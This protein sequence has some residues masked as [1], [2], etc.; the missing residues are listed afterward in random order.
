MK[1]RETYLVIYSSFQLIA[2]EENI[3]EIYIKYPEAVLAII[4]LDKD[5]IE[6][7]KKLK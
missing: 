5:V 1:N 2:V 4:K 7:I 3:S 6:E